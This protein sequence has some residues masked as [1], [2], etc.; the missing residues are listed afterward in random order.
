MGVFN[1]FSREKLEIIQNKSNGKYENL[2]SDYFF[3]KV[4]DNIDR[5]KSLKIIKYNKQIK[6]R[7]NIDINDYKEFAEKFSSIEIEIK[8]A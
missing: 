1:V 5:K 3:K 6:R 8:P 4:F 2:K 7:L